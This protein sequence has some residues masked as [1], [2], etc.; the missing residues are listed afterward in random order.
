[1]PREQGDEKNK[2]TCCCPYAHECRTIHCGMDNIPVAI[3]PRKSESLAPK[4]IAMSIAALTQL[5]F[6]TMIGKSPNS[7]PVFQWL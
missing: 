2:T 6:L 3:P 5:S 4:V 7:S 1:M